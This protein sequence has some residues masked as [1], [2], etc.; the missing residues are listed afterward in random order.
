M[1]AG[2][3]VTSCAH[4]YKAL[5]VTFPKLGVE[6]IPEVRH[7]SEFMA[8]ALKKGALKVKKT[9]SKE[10]FA[11]HD[12]CQLAKACGVYD[13]PREVIA[14]VTGKE[15]RELF[16]SRGEAE[17]CGAG[18]A[19]YITNPELAQ[20]VAK[21]RVDGAVEDGATTLITACPN[22]AVIFSRC[23]GIKI[24]T[25]EELVAENLA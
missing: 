13:A 2:T 5:K 3:F 7:I 10:T 6:V 14:Q 12:P 23:G 20:K 1:K 17:C 4:T 15:P 24:K 19:M 8:E 16:H 22:C 25:I 18:S 9:G 11:Y 21:R